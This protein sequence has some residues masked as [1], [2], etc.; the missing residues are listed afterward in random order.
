MDD[1]NKVHLKNPVLFHEK[2]LKLRGTFFM[3]LLHVCD[4]IFK[5]KF[6]LS[7][8]TYI[9][10]TLIYSVLDFHMAIR[11]D[12]PLPSTP[13][14]RLVYGIFMS[15]KVFRKVGRCTTLMSTDVPDNTTVPAHR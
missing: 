13:Y 3:L 10:N 1:F 2:V 12:V 9:P 5:H 7:T 4:I 11:Q 6:S 14:L 8:P 15:Q